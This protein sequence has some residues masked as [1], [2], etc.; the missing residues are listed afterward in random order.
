[1]KTEQLIYISKPPNRLGGKD[2]IW[3]HA[4]KLYNDNN[5]EKLKLLCHAHYKKV[6]S[7]AFKYYSFDP[8]YYNIGPSG[9]SQAAKDEIRIILRQELKNAKE[10]TVSNITPPSDSIRFR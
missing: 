7:F 4:L 8:S 1:M 3:E 6:A 9:L 5:E 10:I 2:A